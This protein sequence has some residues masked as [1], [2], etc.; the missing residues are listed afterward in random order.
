MYVIVSPTSPVTRALCFP[1]RG[2]ALPQQHTTTNHRSGTIAQL[3]RSFNH[4]LYSQC[5]V[6]SSLLPGPQL[7]AGK[8]L[9]AEKGD[10]AIELAQAG[11]RAIV[12]TAAVCFGSLR[13]PPGPAQNHSATPRSHKR[14]RLGQQRS[15][16]AQGSRVPSPPTQSLRKQASQTDR[17]TDRQRQ[18]QTDRQTDGQTDRRTDRRTDG[19][20]ETETETETESETETERQRDDTWR[21]T[22][23]CRGWGSLPHPK[24]RASKQASK[25]ERQREG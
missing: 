8:Q 24:R 18:T 4:S 11:T 20:T 10:G 12:A 22:G 9:L 21:R 7:N 5:L 14:T 23:K 13:N 2:D 19:R 3:P 6:P 1:S 15:A 17:Q 16:T 25:T